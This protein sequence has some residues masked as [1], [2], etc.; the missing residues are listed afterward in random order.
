MVDETIVPGEKQK[1]H[2][3]VLSAPHN[4]QDLNSKL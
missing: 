2:K 1:L 4:G 3:V